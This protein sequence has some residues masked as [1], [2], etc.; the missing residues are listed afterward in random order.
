MYISKNIIQLCQ[1]TLKL[2]LQKKKKSFICFFQSRGRV[3][4]SVGKGICSVCPHS[5]KEV[6][7]L[8]SD[9]QN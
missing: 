2:S 3:W 7:Q 6:K 9:V 8:S 4:V 1:S 5:E